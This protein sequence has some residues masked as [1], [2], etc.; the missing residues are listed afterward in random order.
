M[1]SLDRV[2]TVFLSLMKPVEQATGVRIALY[3]GSEA[4]FKEKR[5]VA[6][7]EDRNGIIS[8]VVSRKL[9]KLPAENIVGVLAHEIAHG[10]DMV[11]DP[12]ILN[13]AHPDLP[14]TPE[15]RA[16]AL[17]EKLF[18]GIL[19][20]YDKGDVETIGPGNWPRPAHLGP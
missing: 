15:L 19:I 20:S 4:E 6:Y 9:E 14:R 2:T 16:D 8:I 7:A 3:L 1:N 18:P 12:I 11:S 10:V 17:A 13:R 5:Q